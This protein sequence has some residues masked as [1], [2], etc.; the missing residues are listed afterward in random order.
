M[1]AVSAT[2]YVRSRKTKVDHNNVNAEWEGDLT[3][4]LESP[5]DQKPP[6]GPKVGDDSVSAGSTS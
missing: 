6:R 2:I 4:G 3:A 1:V 5:D